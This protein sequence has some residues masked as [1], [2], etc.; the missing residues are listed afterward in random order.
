MINAIE[1]N[2]LT[3][4]F[5]NRTAVDNLNLSVKRGELVSLLGLNGAGKT[6]TIKMLSCLIAPTSGDAF[7]LGES[8]NT[9]PEKVKRK[10]NVSPQETAVALNLTVKENLRF[11]AA[12][13]GFGKEEAALKS[14]AFM[15]KFHLKDRAEDK[16]KLLSGGLQRRLSIAM[17]LITEPEIVFLDEPTLGLDVKARRELWKIIEELKGGD[18]TVILTTHYLEEAEKL[19]DRIAVMQNG[20][21]AAYGTVNE[22]KI[23]TGKENFEEVFLSLTEEEER[24][25]EN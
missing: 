13:Y 18:V 12:L 7:L 22:L 3:K 21:L 2:N 4:K 14:E 17:A 1:L 23:L 6:T 8:I 24:E 16:A 11:I 20:K 10:I 5:K 25:N 19:S 9:A 15:E